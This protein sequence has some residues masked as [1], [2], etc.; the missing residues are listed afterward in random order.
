MFISDK[1]KF[2]FIHIPKTAG[3]SIKNLLLP[4]ANKDQIKFDGENVTDL[5]GFKPHKIFT[6]EDSLKYKDYFKFC[7][8]RNPFERYVSLWK[9]LLNRPNNEINKE[10]MSFEKFVDFIVSRKTVHSLLQVEYFLANQTVSHVD[11]VGRY[12]NLKDDVKKLLEFLKIEES[13]DNL[14][15][16]K[17]SNKYDYKSYYNEKTRKLIEN[18]ARI[19]LDVLNYTF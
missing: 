2:A 17:K 3:T 8:V 11:F 7:F 14:K 13:A 18:H 10:N 12:E 15:H 4:Y 5:N 19:D 1:Y 6:Y 9:F 16:F